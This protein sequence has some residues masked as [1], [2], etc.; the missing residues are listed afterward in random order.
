MSRKNSVKSRKMHIKIY[1]SFVTFSGGN[2]IALS[3]MNT[4]HA[5]AENLPFELKKVIGM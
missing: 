5:S 1:H 2:N 3:G 4:F